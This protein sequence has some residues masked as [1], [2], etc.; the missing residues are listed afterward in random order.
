MIVSDP[1]QRGIVAAERISDLRKQLDINI[2][3][4]YLILNR[5][6]GPIPAALQ[7]RLDQLDVPL[8]GIVPANEDLMEFEF[9][10]RPLVDL[11]IGS[12]VYHAVEQMMIK[13]L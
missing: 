5:L 2:K 1:T 6:N 4:A 3:N 13:M 9:S 12:P 10:G 8:L 11:G 7:Q